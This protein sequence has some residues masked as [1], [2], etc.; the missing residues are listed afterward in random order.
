MLLVD[1][2]RRA[3]L[4]RRGRRHAEGDGFGDAV[5]SV[6]LQVLA[7]LVL[8]GLHIGVFALVQEAERRSAASLLRFGVA[9]WEPLRLAR[10]AGLVLV[11]AAALLGRRAR[12]PAG[13]GALAR[14]A[15]A[16]RA[17]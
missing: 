5:F 14:A 12:L 7:G 16:R 10:L 13:P 2:V 15:A 4:A 17:G 8:I 11:Q 1:P 3:I 9:P 6:A